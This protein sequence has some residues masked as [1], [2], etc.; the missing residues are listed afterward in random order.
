MNLSG[1]EIFITIDRKGSYIPTMFDSAVNYD[2]NKYSEFHYRSGSS[3]YDIR[4]IFYSGV[5]R[6][7]E[8]TITG[9]CK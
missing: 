5:I 3:Y 9:P 7:K 2:E 6:A 4:E 1:H 8:V